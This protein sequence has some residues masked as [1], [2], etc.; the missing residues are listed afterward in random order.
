MWQETKCGV[1]FFVFVAILLSNAGAIWAQPSFVT[2][3]GA[4]PDGATFLIEVP[5]NWNGTLFD[6]D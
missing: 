5:A 1:L 6:D 4:L 3:S 2:R